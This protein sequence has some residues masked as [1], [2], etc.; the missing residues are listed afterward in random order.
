M[1]TSY[2]QNI[3]AETIL[4]TTRGFVSR[5]FSWGAFGVSS[6]TTTGKLQHS[7]PGWL[8]L[9]ARNDLG[10]A[11]LTGVVINGDLS[12]SFGGAKNEGSSA[13]LPFYVNTAET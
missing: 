1:L 6:P 7:S 3:H 8:I 4:Q 10:E 5:C 11:H 12:N 9:K 13:V 2:I